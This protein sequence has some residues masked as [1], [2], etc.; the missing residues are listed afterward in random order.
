[1]FIRRAF[2][3]KSHAPQG[4]PSHVHIPGSR[5][6]RSQRGFTLIEMIATLVLVGILAT[7][8]VMA[9]VQ[10]VKGYMAVKENSATTQKAQLAMTRITREI[11][12]MINIPSAGATA[13]A[14][15]I[16]NIYGNRT[17][18]LDS[19][20]GAVKIAL[21]TDTTNPALIPAVAGGD[22]LIDNVSAFTLTYWAGT[23]T[24]TTALDISALTAIDVLM[25]LTRP[26]G[27]V[28]TF[29]NRISPRNNKN[30]GGATP[31]VSPPTAPNYCFVATAAYGDAGHPMVQILRD[32]R[33]RQLLSWQAGRWFVKQYYEHGPA[34]ADMISNR[35][36]AMW[37]VRCLLAPIVALAFCLTYAPLAIPFILIISFI[38]TGAVF[39]AGRSGL[40]FQTGLTAARGS[41]LI[42]LIVTMVIMATLGAAML[43]MFSASYMNQVYAD[44]GRKTYFVAESGF[45]YAASQFL[46]AKTETAQH[47]AMTDMNGG[48][49]GGGKICN[50]LNNAGSFTTKIYPY[51]FKTISI[52]GTTL[53]TQVYGTTPTEF[54]ST[55]TPTGGNIKV[56]NGYYSYSSRD[57]GSSG[58]GP[59]IRFNGMAA[60]APTTALPASTAGV[61][62]QPWLQT[63][64]STTLSKSGN[65]TLSGS[66]DAFPSLNGNFFLYP[67]PT[68]NNIQ[69][70]AVFNYTKRIGNT[71]YNVTLSDGTQNNNWT[72]AVTVAASTKVVLDRFVRLSS[73]G[74][75]GNASREVIYNVPVGFSGGFQKAGNP[76]AGYQDKF[77]N[78]A[79]WF[80]GQD[81]GTHA[82]TGGAMYVS[83]AVNTTGTTGLLG[84]LAGLLGWGGSGNGIW[85]F[86]ALNWGLTNTNLAQ[87]WMDAGGCLS[88]DLQVKMENTLP[89]FM[90][91]MGFRMRNNSNNSDLYTYGVSFV[92]ARKTRTAWLSNPSGSY[93]QNS[94]MATELIPDAIYPSSPETSSVYSCGGFLGLQRC[95]DQY[96]NP[97]II[98]WQRTGPVT[99]TGAFKYLAYRILT[100]DDGVLVTGSCPNCRLKDWSTLMVRL[101]EGYELPFTR[102]LVDSSSGRHL[103]YGD[104]IKNSDGTKTA[105]IIG[106]PIIT[107]NW[108]SS[109]ST[110]AEG[111]LIL[112]SVTG[113]G[114]TSGEDIY[115]EGG[116]SVAY[117]RAS[118]AQATTKA[119][120]IMVYYS[121]DK[122]PVAGNTVQADNARIGNPREYANWP[123]DDWT[124]RAAGLPTGDPAGNDYSSL[125]QWHYLVA[126]SGLSLSVTP[127]NGWSYSAP[128]LSR[129]AVYGA[130][131]APALTSGNWTLTSGWTIASSQL[132]KSANG[133]TT[134]QPN[135]ALAITA[136]VTYTVSITVTNLTAGSFS[137]TLG[138]VSGGTISAN[139]TYT[140]TITATG[141]GNLI[142]TPTPTNSRFRITAVSVKPQTTA[143]SQIVTHATLT[144]GATYNVAVNVSSLTSGSFYYTIGGCS[145]VYTPCNTT[146]SCNLTC[147]ASTTAPLTFVSPAA[148][149]LFTI[150]SISVTPEGTYAST[151]DTTADGQGNVASFVSA[152]NTTDFYH[153]VIKT[154]ALLSPAWTTS[155]TTANF[156][157]PHGDL[158]SGDAVSLVTSSN[159]PNTANTTFYD[160]FAIQLDLKAGSG[161]LPPIQQ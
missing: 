71:L 153:A 83:S 110:V 138:G 77:D 52:T 26:D 156:V 109:S 97:A 59:T 72:A 146:G 63:G 58:A 17:I 5:A 64:G 128:N 44:Q 3:M 91:G 124:N 89:Y 148:G 143:D 134:A 19:G 50:L 133:T 123:P 7:V 1:M 68:G 158:L 102:G 80:T 28:L 112:T 67:T 33:D 119:N 49:A 56:G 125:V 30:Q 27:V 142:F 152:L 103:K 62:V 145:N 43:P 85:G 94:D 34:A 40:P 16:N 25:T 147:T 39:S 36:I 4:S 66:A 121:D 107:T 106:T 136:G 61:D 120:Y 95:Q 13:T 105:R 127:A 113:T 150:N 122:T 47:I 116:E 74:T 41:V 140:N 129:V 65:L 79:N 11:I 159:A 10:A 144:V 55:A 93:S 42:S 31:I 2:Q 76:K 151:L 38:I 24:W 108:G 104:T 87:S 118:G 54:S 51:W 45:R 141:T 23:G 155:S 57:I 114:F 96:S 98:L 101:I 100:E 111:R 73:T 81:M 70:G 20:V 37:A 160:D 135:P 9:I 99:G 69:N 18:G 46:A 90:T 161:F 15:T 131:M 84:F 14:I 48:A 75:I 92:R 6:F 82:V 21:A 130:E 137:Y 12:D 8:G 78:G 53:T 86:V 22:I 60:V 117:A 126:G 115:L 132:R 149:N 139:G 29:T 154:S 32:F 88:Y 157:G 35:P